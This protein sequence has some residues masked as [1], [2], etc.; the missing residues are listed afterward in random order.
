M[1]IKSAMPISGCLVWGGLLYVG[2]SL[3]RSV[4]SQNVAGYPNSGQLKLY[5]IIP[6]V[7]LLFNVLLVVFSNKTALNLLLG[8][9]FA[10]IIIVLSVLFF[11]GGGI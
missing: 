10:Q 4:I 8:A 6:A 5:I 11:W 9:F 1:K 7:G 3:Y 2:L